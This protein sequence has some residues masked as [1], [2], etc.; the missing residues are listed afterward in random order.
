MLS[1]NKFP[2]LLYVAIGAFCLSVCAGVHI[3]N[4]DVPQ[5]VEL[6]SHESVVLDCEY[7]LGDSDGLVVKWFLN[8]KSNLVY[9]WIPPRKPQDI[10]QFKGKLDLDYRASQDPLQKYRALKILKLGADMSGNYSCVVSTFNDEDT[11]SK[12][13]LIFTPGKNFQLRQEKKDADS[14]KLV[15]F[16]E[17]VFPQPTISITSQSLDLKDVK[18]DVAAG[19]EGLFD[20]VASVLVKNSDVSDAEEFI[21]EMRL[22]QANY[23]KKK[24]TIYYPGSGSNNLHGPS[25]SLHVLICLI[26][27][28]TGYILHCNV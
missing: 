8:N 3:D 21:C 2:F 23:T 4:M 16:A 12:S 28:A 15:C 25:R 10:G 6:G 17:D 13:M 18:I 7:T 19:A 22:P 14:V 20:V 1:L 24:Q 26:Y 27:F 5:L 9:Q 11:K